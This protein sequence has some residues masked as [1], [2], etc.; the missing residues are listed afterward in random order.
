MKARH[1]REAFQILHREGQRTLHHP[2][3]HETMLP[4]INLRNVGTTGRPDEVE[5]GRCDHADRILKRRRHV[6]DETEAIG[7][8]PAAVGDAYRGDET[9]AVA[10]S[11]LIPVALDHWWG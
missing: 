8:R 3:D 10:V 9:R 5:R 11:D 6:K 1:G 7:R 4:G 2:V